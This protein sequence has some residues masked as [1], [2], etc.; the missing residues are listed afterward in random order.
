MTTMTN[1]TRYRRLFI[2]LLQGRASGAFG[3]VHEEDHLHEQ[4]EEIWPLL[5]R[6]ERER[7]NADARRLVGLEPREQLMVMLASISQAEVSSS[8]LSG[9]VDQSIVNERYCLVA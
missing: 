1:E 7:F 8:A 2:Q 9:S 4:M 6:E 3:T 5:A